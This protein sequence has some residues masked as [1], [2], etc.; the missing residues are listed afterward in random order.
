MGGLRVLITNNALAAHAGSELWVRDVATALL[1]RGHTP[2]AFSPDLGAVAEELRRQTIPVVDRLDAVGVPLDLIHGQHH[3]ETMTALLRFPGIP[4]VYVCHGWT[5]WQEAPPRFPRIRRYVAVDDTCRDRLVCEHGVPET[6]VRVLLN[7]VDLARFAPRD[8][9]PV[10]PRRAL[11]FSNAASEHTHLPAVRAACAQA[12]ISVDALGIEAGTAVPCPEDVIGQYDVVFAK[13]RSALEAMAVGAAVVLCD[14]NGVGPLVT[15]ANFDRLRRLNFGIRASREPVSPETLCREL[16][17]YDAADAAAV[18]TRLRGEGAL[19]SAV[20][21]L[22]DIYREVLAEHAAAPAADPAEECRAAS[23]YLGWLGPFLKQQIGAIELRERHRARSEHVRLAAERDRARAD[24]EVSRAETRR[25]DEAFH[26]LGDELAETRA[27]ALAS[28]AELQRVRLDRDRTLE[29]L[30]VLRGSLTVRSRERLLRT[31]IV[32]R[33]AR[34][35]LRVAKA[36]RPWPS[37][38]SSGSG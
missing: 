32:G 7:A 20:D 6:Q 14:A 2:I 26:R 3:L 8:P 29:A 27:A 1:A 19:E 17:G 28:D 21:E 34:V 11:V 36:G 23:D 25:L 9:L 10:R 16:A 35:L 33:L 4:A 15:S 12:G 5:P 38:A 18:T 31:P 30:H 24:E 13:G 37:T 22:L